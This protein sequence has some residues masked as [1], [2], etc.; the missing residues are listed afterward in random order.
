MEDGM[1]FFETFQDLLKS[2]NNCSAGCSCINDRYEI[3]HARVQSWKAAAGTKS[4][5]V[6]VSGLNQFKRANFSGIDLEQLE[7]ITNLPFKIEK[8]AAEWLNLWHYL[9]TTEAFDGQL[10]IRNA[11]L[12]ADI[13]KYE[14]LLFD[15]KSE[16]MNVNIQ[17]RGQLDWLTKNHQWQSM[18]RTPLN[19]K[20]PS[21]LIYRFI[22]EPGIFE[23]ELDEQPFVDFAPGLID[24]RL[25]ECN[26]LT[27]D[28][29]HSLARIQSLRV[30]S[31]GSFQIQG[32]TLHL[33]SNLRNLERL[34]LMGCKNI[35]R[36]AIA[37]LQAQRPNLKILLDEKPKSS[38]S[39]PS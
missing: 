35:S 38:T 36:S 19:S 33:L 15:E 32:E 11:W 18:A 26:S 23:S 22:A 2:T 20:I 6:L 27:D 1:N 28:C 3:T 37:Q 10:A 24:V 30:L 9:L 12:D 16:S 7:E 29:I 17:F 5:D 8:E 14:T 39:L 4:C 21:N 13:E 31:L 25:M 34:D